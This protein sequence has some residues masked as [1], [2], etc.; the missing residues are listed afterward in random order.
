MMIGR[1]GSGP[2]SSH[3]QLIPSNKASKQTSWIRR[4][5]KKQ[6]YLALG[7]L[8]TWGSV[9]PAWGAPA[10]SQML[11]YRP[12]QQDVSVSTPATEAQD[13]CKVELV[14]GRGKASGWLLRDPQGQPLRYFYDSNGDNR[15]DIWSYYQEG[16]EI[17]REIDQP[18]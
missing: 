2:A 10:V 14:K 7:A 12:R 1:T 18:H 11:G 16:V 9:T 15:I 5:L 17:Y 3:Q 13:A 6:K 4:W 8:L